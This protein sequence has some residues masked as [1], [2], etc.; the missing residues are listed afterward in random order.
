[1][2]SSGSTSTNSQAGTNWNGYA[3]TNLA[4]D[5]DG[6]DDNTVTG[7][8]EG[9]ESSPFVLIA[10]GVGLLVM[11]VIIA[12]AV[13]YRCGVNKVRPEVADQEITNIQPSN[14]EA[15]HNGTM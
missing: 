7:A 14:Q 4:V 10:L 11:A 15:Q 9:K 13:A 12:T 1:V 8:K 6:S 3:F 2:S 5:Q